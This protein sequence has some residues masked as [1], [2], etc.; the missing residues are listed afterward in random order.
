MPSSVCVVGSANW[1]EYGRIT[2]ILTVSFAVSWAWP[3]I[4]NRLGTK[5][6]IPASKTRFIVSSLLL[7]DVENALAERQRKAPRNQLSAALCFVLERLLWQC[8]QAAKLYC[9]SVLHRRL[10]R[11]L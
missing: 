4:A 5:A 7:V 2:P 9:P 8:P 3:G 10:Y 11:I 1:P 6:T